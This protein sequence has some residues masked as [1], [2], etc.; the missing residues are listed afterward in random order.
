MPSGWAAYKQH[1]HQPTDLVGRS[2]GSCRHFGCM[3]MDEAMTRRTS[4]LDTSVMDKY[5]TPGTIPSRASTETNGLGL[6]DGQLGGKDLKQRTRAGPG[7]SPP[8]QR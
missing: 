8:W 5:T 7:N 3:M 4:F 6:H 1:F 2:G